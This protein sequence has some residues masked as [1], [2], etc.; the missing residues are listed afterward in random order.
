MTIELYINKSDKYHLVKELTGRTI[1][2]GNLIDS[3]VNI[4]RPEITLN[5]GDENRVTTFNYVKIP[6]FNNR[7][8]FIDNI[9]NI[10]RSLWKISCSID[11]RSTYASDIKNQVAIISRQ[12]N[13]Y[14]NKMYND[15]TYETTVEEVVEIKEFQYKVMDSN[16]PFYL[17]TCI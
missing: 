16:A 1:A 15:D 6:A 8:Y 13:S 17:L 12:E 10:N 11:V 9:I 7:C 14:N 5:F 2:T 4:L 3:G